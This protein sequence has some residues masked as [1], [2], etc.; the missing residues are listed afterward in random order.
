MKSKD[1][2]DL[3]TNL[4][5]DLWT[6]SPANLLAIPSSVSWCPTLPMSKT[7]NDTQRKKCGI[8]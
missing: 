2:I 3:Q 8:H 4:I 1:R 6:T 7:K 5:S